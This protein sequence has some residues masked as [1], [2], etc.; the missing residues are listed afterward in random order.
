MPTAGTAWKGP[1]SACTCQASRVKYF[2]APL[3]ERVQQAR[4]RRAVSLV[5]PAPRE[6]CTQFPAAGPVS[7]LVLPPG[8]RLPPGYSPTRGD[9]RARSRSGRG[10]GFPTPTPAKPWGYCRGYCRLYCRSTRGNTHRGIH[11]SIHR[12]HRARARCCQSFNPLTSLRG[13]GSGGFGGRPEKS[14]NGDDRFS[15]EQ[16]KPPRS[17]SCELPPAPF[18]RGTNA[19]RTDTSTDTASASL[20]GTRRSS[21]TVRGAHRIPAA[22]GQKL[23]CG[24]SAGSSQLHIRHILGSLFRDTAHPWVFV[25]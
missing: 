10:P 25:A 14:I 15:V 24:I 9:P 7:F 17:S 4:E 2:F 22:W 16:E 23:A 21:C 5:P 18:H 6:A 19:P 13:R 3:R 1:Q 12:S 20:E 8:Y 11:K